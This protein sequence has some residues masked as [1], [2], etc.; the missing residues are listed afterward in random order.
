MKIRKKIQ[1]IRSLSQLWQHRTALY[2]MFRDA[3]KGKFKLSVLTVISIVLAGLYILS[4]IDFLPDFLPILGWVDDGIIFYFLLKRLMTELNRY[5]Q[6]DLA[7]LTEAEY[8][9]LQK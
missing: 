5:A 7:V 3:W 8:K 1:Q 2:A 4:P 9:N 6:R